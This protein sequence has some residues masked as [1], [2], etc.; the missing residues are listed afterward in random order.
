MYIKPSMKS[1]DLCSLGSEA[2]K[3][4]AW[5]KSWANSWGNN[6]AAGWVN[7]WIAYA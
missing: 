3:V 1:M 2:S 4:Q 5:S 6:W 7:G